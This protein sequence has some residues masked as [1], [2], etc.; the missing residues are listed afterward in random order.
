MVQAALGEMVEGIW[1]DTSQ[2]GVRSGLLE[3]R[4]RK[5]A[6]LTLETRLAESRILHGVP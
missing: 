1:G 4:L 2:Q 3:I 6:P 5:E